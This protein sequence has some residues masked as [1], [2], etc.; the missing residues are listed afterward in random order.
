MKCLLAV[1]L[2]AA[3]APTAVAFPF[4]VPPADLSD[5]LRENVRRL[6]AE[7]E[8]ERLQA[9]AGI[10]A[11]GPWGRPAL[12]ALVEVYKD[13]SPRLAQPMRKRPCPPS[14]RWFASPDSIASS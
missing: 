6:G 7:S 10:R 14:S 12:P 5:R 2:A 3:V 4:P 9:V 8:D 11:L 13:A 1:V